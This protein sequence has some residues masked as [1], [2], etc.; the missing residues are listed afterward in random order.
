M[1]RTYPAY[2]TLIRARL[3]SDTHTRKHREECVPGDLGDI[4]FTN[5]NCAFCFMAGALG[6]HPFADVSLRSLFV[7][8]QYLLHSTRYNR[9]AAA[10]SD[11]ARDSKTKSIPNTPPRQGL[12]LRKFAELRSLQTPR[13]AIP[14]LLHFLPFCFITF[15][16]LL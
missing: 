3:D 6:M 9:A 7:Y 13:S 10:Q 4:V 8:V 14:V 2:S 16:F 1:L 11:R 12:P 15:P 5:E